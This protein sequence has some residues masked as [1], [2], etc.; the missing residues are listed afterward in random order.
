M[1]TV[2]QWLGNASG[3]PAV[4]LFCACNK[5]GSS[6]S[7]PNIPKGQ[8]QVSLYMMDG[9]VS[10]SKVLIDIRQVTVEIDTATTQNAPDVDDQWDA[11]YCGFHRTGSNKSVTLDSTT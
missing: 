3:G 2:I 5:N 10:L 9:P 8:S 6:S 4:L 11:N 1:K 7:N